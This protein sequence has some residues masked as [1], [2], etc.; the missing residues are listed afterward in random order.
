MLPHL[1]QS[2]PQRFQR[3]QAGKEAQCLRGGFKKVVFKQ[4]GRAYTLFYEDVE[5]PDG[6]T[7]TQRARHPIGDLSILSERAAR[8]EHDLFMAEVNRRRGSVPVTIEG[9]T[10]RDAVDAWKKD[11]A[12]QLSPATV[13]QRESYLRTHGLPAF[14]K[15]ALH[16]LDVRALQQFATTLQNNLSPKTVINIL[17]TIF[18]VLRYAKRCGTKTSPVSFSDLTIRNPESPE[19]PFFTAEQVARIVRAAKGPENFLLRSPISTKFE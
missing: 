8:R 18:A 6:T 12:P 7:T 15:E 4:N 3:A 19:R 16:A 14:A 5:R 13:R 1:L 9:E 10:F 2:L 11:V 17:E